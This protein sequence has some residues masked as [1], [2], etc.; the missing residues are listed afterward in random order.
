MT[1]VLVRQAFQPDCNAESPKLAAAGQ[2]P[3]PWNAIP[4]SLPPDWM[5]ELWLE[6]RDLFEHRLLSGWKA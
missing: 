1:N 6:P 5:S 2:L 3:D 4:D